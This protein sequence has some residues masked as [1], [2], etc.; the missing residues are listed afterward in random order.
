MAGRGPAS[1]PK[2]PACQSQHGIQAVPLFSL[3]V[4]HEEKE[5]HECK[6]AVKFA[7]SFMIFFVG[8]AVSMQDSGSSDPCSSPCGVIVLCS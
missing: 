8:G 7:C 5:G 3:S 1:R 4:E 2:F 6:M